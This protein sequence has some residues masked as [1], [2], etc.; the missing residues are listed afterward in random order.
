MCRVVH[1]RCWSWMLGAVARER[2]QVARELADG[3]GC[4]REVWKRNGDHTRL[5]ERETMEKILMAP[6]LLHCLSSPVSRVFFVL[7]STKRDVFPVRSSHPFSPSGHFLWR[8]YEQQS[9]PSSPK[10]RRG[11]VQR[12]VYGVS[13]SGGMFGRMSWLSLRGHAGGIFGRQQVGMIGRDA[14]PIG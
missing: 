11:E 9:V 5:S 13:L 7:V 3:R 1:A 14:P 10:H 6:P 4:L 2:L 12:V 8:H